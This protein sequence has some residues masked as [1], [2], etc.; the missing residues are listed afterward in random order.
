[1][2]VCRGDIFYIEGN[3]RTEGSEQRADRPALVVSNDIG[4][5]HSNIVS[6]VYLTTA[7][8]KPLPTHCEVVAR[9]PSTAICEQ[10]VTISQS[11]LGEYIRTATE[12]E[13]NE[14]DKCLMIALGLNPET[15]NEQVIATQ[16][17]IDDLMMKLDELNAE[18][19]GL[20]LEN[21]DLKE[22][23]RNAEKQIPVF[24]AEAEKELLKAEI[25]RDMYK[26]LYKQMLEKM[27]G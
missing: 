23:L 12:A 6:V 24:P 11:R 14:I 7:E 25:Q 15:Q 9:I 17:M 1:M 2:D 5:H 18:N 8:K 16:G 22:M 19:A 21:G 27:V 4:N 26:E 10:V 13:M 20:A 3:N